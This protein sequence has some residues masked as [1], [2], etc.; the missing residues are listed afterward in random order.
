MAESFGARLREHRERQQIA[1]TFIA[2]KTKLSLSLLEGLE[3]DDVSQ[4]PTGIFRRSFIRDYARLIGLEPDLIAREFLELYPDHVKDVLA[5]AD[6][7]VDAGSRRPPMRLRYLVASAISSIRAR[8]ENLQQLPEARSDAVHPD[9][10]AYAAAAR[11]WVAPGPHPGPAAPEPPPPVAE[12]PVEPQPAAK[13]F[14]AITELCAALD[15]TTAPREVGLL[16]D[17]ATIILEATGMVV[18]TWDPR[19]SALKPTRVHG[20]PVETAARLPMVRPDA[21]NATAAAFRS[22]EIQIVQGGDHV[23][24]AVVAP[25]LTPAGCLGVLAIELQHGGEQEESVRALATRL[26]AQVA[27]SVLNSPP[28]AEVAAAVNT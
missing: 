3:R 19:A 22:A 18:W 16:L 15:R 5:E 2:E 9:V 14:S 27:Q 28:I 6:L 12:T 7:P 23:S 25:L 10:Q 26:A 17:Y 13:E 21:D 8:L 20:Y 11:V 4:W 24:G 1:L